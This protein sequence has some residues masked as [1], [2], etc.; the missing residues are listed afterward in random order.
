MAQLRTLLMIAVTTVLVTSCSNAAVDKVT[1]ATLDPINQPSQ[2]IPDEALLDVGIPTLD[3]GLDLTDEK[4]TVLP[5]VRYAESVFMADRIAKTLQKSNAWGAVRVIPNND[6]VVDLYVRGVIEQSD[7]ETLKLAITVVDTSG[8]VWYKKDYKQMV[9]KYTYDRR[10]R[11][12]NDPFQNL[13]T[14]IANDL[15]AF[16]EKMSHDDAVALRTLSELRF[17]KAFSPEAFGEHVSENRKGILK[18]ERLP[19]ENDTILARV[20]RI[21]DKDYLYIDTMQDYYERFSGRMQGPYQDWRKGSYDYVQ[22]VRQMDERARAKIFAGV[23]AIA[24]GIYGRNTANDGYQYDAA[25]IG[26]GA[27]GVLIKSGLDDRNKA[28]GYRESLS[29]MGA[30]LSAELEPQVIELDDSTITLTGTVNNQYEQWREL[31]DKIYRA[32]RGDTATTAESADLS[33]KDGGE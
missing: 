12:Q 23:I 32:E 5:E 26:A 27:G 7:G 18:I 17:A 10:I 13:Y 4:D 9:G 31:L 28:A 14:E 19:A 29:E 15:L 22:K 33:T 20:N 2:A 8:A 1:S 11:H 21:R 24:A 6:I 25:T 3:P 30:S 16:R